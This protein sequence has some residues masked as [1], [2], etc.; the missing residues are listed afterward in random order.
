HGARSLLV[1]LRL[2]MDLHRPLG[3]GEGADEIGVRLG[4][5]KAQ[6]VIVDDLDTGVDIRDRPAPVA[7]R[8][9]RGVF[10]EKLP[11]GVHNVSGGELP[12]A[13]LELNAP[14]QLKSVRSAVRL[15][16]PIR[17]KLRFKL[18]GLGV[19]ADE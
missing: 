18:S 15:E 14:P 17:G 6:F 16:A 3:L 9:V 13:L 19:Q 8:C 5:V 11:P 7:Q 2:A 4:K 12:P 1:E 10:T